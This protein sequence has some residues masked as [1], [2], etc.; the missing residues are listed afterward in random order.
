MGDTPLSTQK[1]IPIISNTTSNKRD[2]NKFEG[3]GIKQPN[4]TS[5]NKLINSSNINSSTKK[6]LYER[7]VSTDLKRNINKRNFSPVNNKTMYKED[8]PEHFFVD[9]FGMFCLDAE[10]LKEKLLHVLNSLSIKYIITH[11][12]SY[13][14]KC[15]KSGLKFDLCISD[16][17]FSS[18]VLNKKRQGNNFSYKELVTSIYKRLNGLE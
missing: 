9:L 2:Q 8:K 6:K 16:C 15:E 1:K 11:G 3:S 5:K 18:S 10:A 12:A 17:Y 13:T 4:I 7:A 14:I